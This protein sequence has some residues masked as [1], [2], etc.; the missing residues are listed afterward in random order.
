MSKHTDWEA[1]ER[2]YR[3]GQLSVREIASRH[4]INASTISRR[5]KRDGWER[6]LTDQVRQRA[7]AKA[8]ESA[9]QYATQHATQ[10][11]RNSSNARDDEIVEAA[12]ERGAEVINLHR[13]DVRQ[14]RETVEMMLA[15]LRTECQTPG[16][17]QMAEQHI[18]AEGAGQQQ[19]NAI[20]KAVSLPARAGV[21][22]D[23]SQSM[24][25]LIALERQAFNLDEDGSGESYEDQ[26]RRL[27]DG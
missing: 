17:E 27:M 12:A 11:E 15:E 9:G 3:A 6:D 18:E 26:L 4:S 22:R 13:R 16:L 25:R 10:H 2:E 24:Q 1:I 14:G 5:A 8:T 21:M 19:A 20:R 7:K 23:L